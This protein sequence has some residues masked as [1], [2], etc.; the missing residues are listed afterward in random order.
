MASA[1]QLT[2]SSPRN[3]LVRIL[4]CGALA[5]GC[6]KHVPLASA[7]APLTPPTRLCGS[8][9]AE[10]DCRQATGVEQVLRGELELLGMADTPSGA[11]GAKLLTLRGKTD[12]GPI[13]LRAK[14]R[15]QS[16]G[17]LLNEPRKELAAYAVQKLF[18]DPSELVAPPTAAQCLPLDEYRKFEPAAEA[19]FPGT[20][21]VFGYVSYWLESAQSV[22]HARK[23]GLMGPG[24]GIWDADLFARDQTYKESVARCNLLT[25]AI[26]HGDA[27]DE[28]FLLEP[29]RHG[30]RAYVV[31]NS[32][33]FRSI[34]NPLLLLRQDWSNIQLPWLPPRSLARMRRLIHEDFARLSTIAVLERDGD[35]LRNVPLAREQ[36]SDGTSLQWRGSLLRIGL[37]RGEIELVEARVRALLAKEP[38]AQA[39]ASGADYAVSEAR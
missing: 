35:E 27:H 9:G 7:A 17:D 14:W 16:S 6:S 37:T 26:N 39:S 24:S 23:A 11:Q 13:V 36:E 12:R 28:Q 15:A 38:A 4:A 31:D 1:A 19:T 34:K 5:L 22:N 20:E 8:A 21:C 30:L 10:A 2:M 32:I 18:L 3:H 25:Y 29:T 33:A